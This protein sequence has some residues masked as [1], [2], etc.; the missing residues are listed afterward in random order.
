VPLIAIA[1]ALT[2]AF[3]HASWNALLKS[4]RDR[5]ADSFLTAIGGAL[6]GLALVAAVGWPAQAAWPF[7]FASMFVHCAYWTCL[8][9]SYD[10]GD[11]SHIYTLSRGS[12]PLLVAVGA[13][14]AVREIPSPA[15]AAGIVLV[16]A[17]VLCVGI[18]PRA[19]LRATAWALTTGA[20]IAS[21]SLID[22]LGA[23]AS[24]DAASYVGC[25]TVLMSVP[26]AMFAVFRRGPRLYSDILRDPWRGLAAGAISSAGYGIVLWA[27]T[28]AP[29]A[30]VTALRETS[31]VFG[32]LLSW[33][34]LKEAMG[35]R[36]WFGALIVAGGAL[37]IGFS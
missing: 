24:G 1:A 23:R 27:Q 35:L 25:G 19:S 22:A 12:A 15:D 17:G 7:L 11:L 26:L 3:I 2:S 6:F 14:V 10:A 9:K 8:I 34:A 36:R 21:Y 18:S 33:L 5:L 16:S 4:G 28:I 37:L 31:V 20:C 13:A 32:A 30:Q 29:I